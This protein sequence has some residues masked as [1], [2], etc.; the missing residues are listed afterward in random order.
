MEEVVNGMY[1]QL[2]GR[3]TRD[4]V[5]GT[6]KAGRILKIVLALQDN[7]FYYVITAFDA[8]KEE[9]VLY[10]QMKGDL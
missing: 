8:K 9:V 4:V 1:I 7:D 5:L 3:W 10:K 2:K 6:T